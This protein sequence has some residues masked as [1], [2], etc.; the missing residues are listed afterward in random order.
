[1]SAG[2]SLDLFL[3][4]WR[5]VLRER[6]LR[7]PRLV[8]VMLGARVGGSGRVDLPLFLFTVIGVVAV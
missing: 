3:M 8:V 6:V 4:R 5:L 1:M 2:A 7:C